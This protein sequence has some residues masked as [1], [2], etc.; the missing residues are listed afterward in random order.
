MITL[1]PVEQSPDYT[2]RNY[3]E[4]GEAKLQ[5][6]GDII[7]IDAPVSLL[8]QELAKGAEA[9]FKRIEAPYKP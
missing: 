8:S 4:A 7:S 1:R 3:G 9:G 6:S 2:V 5:P